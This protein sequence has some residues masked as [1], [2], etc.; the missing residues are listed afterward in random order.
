MSHQFI[1]RLLITAEKYI[2]FFQQGIYADDTALMANTES[3]LQE[4]VDV[5]LV[6]YHSSKSR[7]DMNVKQSKVMRV[8]NTDLSIKQ[9]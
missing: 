2:I 6:R 3:K 5:D 9:I 8:T 1:C 4:I 7:L